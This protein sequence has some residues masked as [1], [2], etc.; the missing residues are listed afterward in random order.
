MKVVR[1]DLW[2]DP[3]AMVIVTTNGALRKNGSLVMGRGAALQAAQKFPGLDYTC[4]RAIKRSHA[5]RDSQGNYIYGFIPVLGL[6]DTFIPEIHGIH[7]IFQVKAHWS[8]QASLALIRAST[9]MLAGYAVGNP[10]VTFRMNFPGIGNGQL[11]QMQVE[12]IISMLPDNVVV[13]IQ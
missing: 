4:G 7:G 2:A 12:P 3:K 9:L 8:E 10:N 13:C 5:T 1:E 11:K 6:T